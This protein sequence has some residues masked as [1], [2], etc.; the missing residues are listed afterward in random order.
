MSFQGRNR[1]LEARTCPS[2]LRNVVENNPNSFTNRACIKAINT[3][4]RT[5]LLT[6]HLIVNHDQISNVVYVRAEDEDQAL[7]QRLGRV[8]KNEAE[9]ENDSSHWDQRCEGIGAVENEQ[10]DKEN[11]D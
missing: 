4:R 9:P 5:K 11:Q 6:T 2:T 1:W 7:K 8:A 3:I 10:A